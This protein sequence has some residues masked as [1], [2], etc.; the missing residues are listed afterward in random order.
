MRSSSEIHERMLS[1]VT[2]MLERPTMYGANR[3]FE[4]AFCSRLSDLA[5]IDGRESHLERVWTTLEEAGYWGALGMYGAFAAAVR[6]S[7]DFTEVLASVFARIASALGYFAPARR[8]PSPQWKRMQ[9]DV[10]RWARAEQRSH[11]DIV[12]RF[13]EPAYRASGQLPRVLGYAG[14]TDEGWLYFDLEFVEGG[15]HDGRALRYLRLPI[16]P[17]RR[18]LVDVCQPTRDFS[19]PDEDDAPERVY[20]RFLTALLSGEETAARDLVLPNAENAALWGSA[21]PEDV[22][23]LLGEQ[24]RTMDIVRVPPPAQAACVHL[25]SSGCP[26]AL[27][28]VQTDTG[29]KIDARPLAAMRKMPS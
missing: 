3:A 19:Q 26:V 6:S 18:S 14:P 9:R 8:V 17:L 16:N 21:Y 25:W 23:A 15:A 13:G 11:A 1:Q 20:R 10:G 5:F 4:L 29:W 24:Y 7:E 27:P 12:A 28:V 22:A 2:A